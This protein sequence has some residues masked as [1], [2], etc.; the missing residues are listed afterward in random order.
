MEENDQSVS[1]ERSQ[2]LFCLGGDD[3][4]KLHCFSVL[5]T[6]R[7][8]LDMI[9]NFEQKGAAYTPVFTVLTITMKKGVCLYFCQNIQ[10]LF[11][12]AFLSSGS[13]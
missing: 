12:F 6:D 10:H 9:R 7:S 8:I 3:G 4:N 5:E 1:E 13:Q 2:C 11:Q